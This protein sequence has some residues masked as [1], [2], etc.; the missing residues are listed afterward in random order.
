MR[1]KQS[2]PGPCCRSVAPHRQD[3]AGLQSILAEWRRRDSRP[4]LSRWS[5]S[6]SCVRL[7]H[8]SLPEAGGQLQWRPDERIW[9]FPA[10][11]AAALAA[12]VVERLGLEV[13]QPPKFVMKLFAEHTDGV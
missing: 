3:I 1:H 5:C 8:R 12:A 10:A 9:E 6:P 13:Q 2:L 4:R 7:A 11:A